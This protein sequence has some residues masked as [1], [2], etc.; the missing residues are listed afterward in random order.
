MLMSK[1][2]INNCRMPERKTTVLCMAFILYANNSGG[3]YSP[4][5]KYYFFVLELKSYFVFIKYFVHRIHTYEY[6]Q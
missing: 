1:T 6:E 3:V 5:N 2:T 4:L